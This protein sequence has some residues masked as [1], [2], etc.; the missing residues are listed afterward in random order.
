MGTPMKPIR[1]I[2]TVILAIMLVGLVSGTA[3]VADTSPPGTPATANPIIAEMISQVS[4][5]NIEN[6]TLALQSFGTRAYPVGGSFT[7]GNQQAA[8]W[9]YSQLDAIQGLS[10]AYQSTHKNVIATLS[11]D[12]TVYIVGAHYDD[13]PYTG[14]APGASDNGVGVA[15]VLEMARILSQ[16]EFE[17]TVIF[18]FWNGEEGEKEGQRG[19]H[20]YVAEMLANDVDLGFYHNIDSAAYD[21]DGEFSLDVVYNAKSSWVARLFAAQNTLYGTDFTLTHNR[22]TCT[23]DHRPFSEA[24]G[25]TATFTHSNGGPSNGHSPVVHTADDSFSPTNVSSAYARRH[26]QLT[27]AVLAESAMGVV[28]SG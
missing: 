28:P 8:A 15:M 24:G 10:V 18:A 26:C 25:Y 21:P 16:Y 13:R 3:C 14:S 5:T 9:L 19:S 12:S 22:H 27:M 20:A 11:G 2:G 7:S 17:H 4:E 1:I 23:S 6:S